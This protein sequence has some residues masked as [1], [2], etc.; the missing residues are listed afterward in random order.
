MAKK[1]YLVPVDFSKASSAALGHAAKIAQERKDR[2][3]LVH[4][5]TDPAEG[6]PLPLRSRYYEELASEA[7]E[8]AKD[9]RKKL[10][11]VDY[12]LVVLNGP[13]AARSIAEQA[14]KSRAS[15]IVM[16]SHGRTGLSRLVLGS[17]AARTIRYADCPILIVKPGR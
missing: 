17:V 5:I 13:D 3:L 10:K 12:R 6:V 1:T 9:L 11:E 2:L 14:K 16:G 7:R 8:K 4:V 15:M